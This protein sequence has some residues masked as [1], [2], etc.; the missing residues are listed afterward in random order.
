MKEVPETLMVFAS[1]IVCVIDKVSCI[2][3]SN[4]KLYVPVYSRDF[5]FVVYNPALTWKPCMARA[6][7]VSQFIIGVQKQSA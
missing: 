5:G 3:K 4:E 1:E 2:S 6:P 7:V